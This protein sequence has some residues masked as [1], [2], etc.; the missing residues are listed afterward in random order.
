MAKYVTQ[1]ED[2]PHLQLQSRSWGVGRVCVHWYLFDD[3]WTFSLVLALL[4]ALVKV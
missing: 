4:V 2:P 3:K 1:R